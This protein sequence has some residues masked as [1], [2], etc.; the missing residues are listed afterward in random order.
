MSAMGAGFPHVKRSEQ[1]I[2]ALRGP[3]PAPLAPRPRSTPPLV[4]PP[5]SQSQQGHG[6]QVAVN[7]DSGVVWQPP[8]VTLSL[9]KTANSDMVI[10]IDQSEGEDARNE[11]I[12][13]RL[14]GEARLAT[15]DVAANVLPVNDGLTDG[16]TNG[17][18]ESSAD[19]LPK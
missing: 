1:E 13:R 16:L 5:I 9:D 12:M 19:E 2:V 8:A 17:L 6:T 11:M 7:D 3:A 18:T 15:E 4:A 14:F 10:E